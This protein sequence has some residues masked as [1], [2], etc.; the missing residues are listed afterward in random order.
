[1]GLPR[2]LTGAASQ[3]ARAIRFHYRHYGEEAWQHTNA[4]PLDPA[5]LVRLGVPQVFTYWIAELPD[6]AE[7]LWV[8]ARA[9]G[10]VLASAP[11]RPGG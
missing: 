3:E 2:R 9:D 7:P 5:S 4:I 1:M 10:R 11:G 6:G 8:A